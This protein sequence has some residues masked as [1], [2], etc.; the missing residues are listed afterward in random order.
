M[1]KLFDA[2]KAKAL[3]T[4]H[5]KERRFNLLASAMLIFLMVLD[6][7]IVML[8]CRD[9]YHVDDILFISLFITYLITA[10]FTLM[11]LLGLEQTVYEYDVN[12]GISVADRQEESMTPDSLIFLILFIPGMLVVGL[13]TAGVL[14]ITGK[15]T[16]NNQ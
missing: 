1:K 12:H 11:F 16:G 7:S 15:L 5:K 10:F 14:L 9:S 13:L 2:K 6:Y 4:I 8:L 3:R